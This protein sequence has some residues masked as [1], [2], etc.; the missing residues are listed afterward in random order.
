MENV[1]NSKDKILSFVTSNFGEPSIT[2]D[3]FLKAINDNMDWHE[4]RSQGWSKTDYIYC[5]LLTNYLFFKEVSERHPK[6]EFLTNI[7]LF[8][9]ERAIVEKAIKTLLEINYYVNGKEANLVKR[10]ANKF[11]NTINS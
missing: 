7:I 4:M 11:L 3:D 10:W 6:I 8:Y 5:S 9:K 1:I 2:Y